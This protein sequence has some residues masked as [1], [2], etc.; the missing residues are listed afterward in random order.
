M[1]PSVPL[2]TPLLQSLETPLIAD[3]YIYAAMLP[4]GSTCVVQLHS[5]CHAHTWAIFKMSACLLTK[6][7]LLLWAFNQAGRLITIQYMRTCMTHSIVPVADNR[8]D[9]L[10][11]LSVAV[12]ATTQMVLAFPV[13]LAAWRN[14]EL[15]K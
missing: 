10:G 11:I 1:R 4:T 9:S 8:I 5:Q 2:S 6:T 14:E 3:M 12:S 7:E 15:K 13:K